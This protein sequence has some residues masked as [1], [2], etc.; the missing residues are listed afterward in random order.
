MTPTE[1]AC[2]PARPSLSPLATPA[3]RTI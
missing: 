3:S 1:V 2:S